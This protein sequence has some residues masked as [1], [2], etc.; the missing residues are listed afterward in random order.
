MPSL[1]KQNR[2]PCRSLWKSDHQ[3][4]KNDPETDKHRHFAERFLGALFGDTCG[5]V[6]ADTDGRRDHP[7]GGE[8][9]TFIGR[10]DMK[11]NSPDV[12]VR[13][14]IRLVRATK[15]F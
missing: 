1:V 7:D 4:T 15:F 14:I 3:H 13:E 11:K 6:D 8:G 5:G 2:Q 9:D 12:W 10:M